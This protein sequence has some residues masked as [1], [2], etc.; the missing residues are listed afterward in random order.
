MPSTLSLCGE[1]G[2]HSA[3]SLDSRLFSMVFCP[4]MVVSYSF[5]ESSEVG[6]DLRHH[7]GNVAPSPTFLSILL[8]LI[9]P[10][11][12]SSGIFFLHS[13]DWIWT[14]CSLKWLY[15]AHSLELPWLL[16]WVKVTTFWKLYLSVSA[17][18]FT[19]VYSQANF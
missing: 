13:P 6:K 19:G 15:C 14:V 18:I 8:T 11:P 17:L 1:M 5:C 3:S 4:W 2:W 7:L 12:P 16:S 10:F 9:N